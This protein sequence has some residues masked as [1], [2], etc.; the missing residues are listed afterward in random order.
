[1][2]IESDLSFLHQA[3]RLAVQGHGSVEP[4]PLVGCIITNV[5]GAIVGEGFHKHVFGQNH[6]EI[7]A[8][9]IAGNNAARWHCIRHA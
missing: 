2:N 5:Q 8:L 3:V 1:M 6:A 9:A 7:N 4:N